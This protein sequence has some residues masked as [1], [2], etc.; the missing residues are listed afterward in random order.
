MH[1]VPI[2]SAND[3]NFSRPKLKA[4]Q[5]ALKAVREKLVAALGRVDG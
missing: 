4:T 5:E 1:L 2:N 3:L